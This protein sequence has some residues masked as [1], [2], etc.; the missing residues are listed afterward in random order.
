MIS[1]KCKIKFYHYYFLI[2]FECTFFKYPLYVIQ[3]WYK[4]MWVSEAEENNRVEII[5]YEEEWV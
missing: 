2:L 4:H 5:I 1:V 3:S